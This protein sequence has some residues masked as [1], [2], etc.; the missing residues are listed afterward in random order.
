M[1]TAARVC[2]PCCSLGNA[3]PGRCVGERGGGNIAAVEAADRNQRRRLRGSLSGS[4]SVGCRSGNCNAQQRSG[5]RHTNMWRAYSCC[6]LWA[7]EELPGGNP[8][9]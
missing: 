7:G 4:V 9:L 3:E 6:G 2:L 1:T 8:R 5:Q